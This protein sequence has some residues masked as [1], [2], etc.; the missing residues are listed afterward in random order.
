MFFM[1][2]FID[3]D[4]L[5]SH[6]G[7]SSLPTMQHLT[8]EA[9][10]ACLPRSSSYNSLQRRLMRNKATSIEFGL[11]KPDENTNNEEVR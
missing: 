9:T 11:Q 5:Q 6:D 8:P 2:L 1:F 4:S 7:Y 3:L 10:S